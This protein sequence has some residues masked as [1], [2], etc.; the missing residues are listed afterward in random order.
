MPVLRSLWADGSDSG[1]KW[2]DALTVSP[3][4]GDPADRIGRWSGEGDDEPESIVLERYGQS[5]RRIRAPGH[6]L[7]QERPVLHRGDVRTLCGDDLFGG[8]GEMTAGDRRQQRLGG[9]LPQ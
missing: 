1:K 2:A 3:E 8:P 5:G 6:V 4:K 7:D 9:N